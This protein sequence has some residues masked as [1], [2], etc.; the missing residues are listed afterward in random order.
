LPKSFAKYKE[1]CIFITGDNNM[2]YKIF[3]IL[4]LFILSCVK[5]NTA[6]QNIIIEKMNIYGGK[7]I[8]EINR[9]DELSEVIYTK[10]IRYYNSNEEVVKIVSV[11]KNEIIIS[12]GM[13]E[14]IQYYENNNIVKYEMLFSDEY[15]Y[16]YGF[17]RLI[18]E[19]NT[20]DVVT[21]KIWYKDEIILSN[22]ELGETL[23]EF[24]NIEFIDSEYFRDYQSSEND[25][26]DISGKYFRIQSVI[27]FGTELI[28]LSDN[29]IKLMDSFSN[30][31]GLDIFSQYYSKKVRA[32]SDNKV[33]WLYV[34]PQLEEYI[35]GQ[36]A[37]I[38]YYPIGLN[39]ELYLICV[40][41]FD[42][43]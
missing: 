29:D 25:V 15:Y 9:S 21:K 18:E 16:I 14:Q 1:C 37:S 7:T 20:E 39:K 22:Y 26:I 23:F 2:K 30:A 17:N 13:K 24:Y 34:Q 40:G 41:F 28:E 33:Y 19:V 35:L 12:T 5:N 38:K 3:L 4:T 11:L 6:G 32:Y 27:K 8:E 10:L 31:F 42:I 43:N 36:A